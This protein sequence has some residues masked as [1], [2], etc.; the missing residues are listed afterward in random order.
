MDVTH[1]YKNKEGTEAE[2]LAV[3]NAVRGVPRAQEL[4]EIPNKESEDVF[5]DL[6]DIDTVPFGENFTVVVHI[7][8]KATEERTIRAIISSSSVY[9]TGT[10]AKD[11]KKAQA[12]F[13]VGPGQKEIIR[14]EV[15]ATDYLN[16][17]V[18]H[19]LIKIHSIANVEE[20]KQTWSE[21]DDFTL[22]LPDISINVVGVCKVG[23]PCKVNFRS[24]TELALFL[25]CK[26]HLYYFSFHNPLKF[27][28]TNCRYTLEGPGQ[29]KPVTTKHR[30]INPQEIITIDHSFTAKKSGERRIVV[31]FTSKEIHQIN[32]STTVQIQ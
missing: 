2:R 25:N 31:S 27:P 6:V 15:N 4:Y 28:L 11:I 8:N 24:V 3:Y 12:K 14:M 18:D 10:F 9:Y 26:F 30:D 23:E 7:V 1:L 19:S 13:K 22:I 21:E 29:N 32:G 16:K 5:F 20:T 17:L